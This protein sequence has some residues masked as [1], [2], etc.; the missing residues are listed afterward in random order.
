M[1]ILLWLGIEPFIAS[2]PAQSLELLTQT[3]FPLIREN[4]ARRLTLDIDR[5]AETVTRL[6]SLAA[7]RPQLTA[8]ILRGVAAAV[9]GRT[10]LPKPA[11]WSELSAKLTAINRG[12]TRDSLDVIGVAFEDNMIISS[13]RRTAKHTGSNPEKRT[14]AL[15]LLLVARPND[16]KE[17][18]CEV[19]PIGWAP[20]RVE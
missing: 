16:L 3:T 9:E 5:D 14:C 8:D 1:A 7:D 15:Q 11:H 17:E 18:L 6:L 2:H 20:N 4:I 19:D 12:D 10:N 13:L